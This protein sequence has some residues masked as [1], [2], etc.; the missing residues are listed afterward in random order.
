MDKPRVVVSAILRDLKDGLTRDAIG[1]KYGLDKTG[2]KELFQNKH[3]KN[4]KTHKPKESRF[5]LI[6]D[7]DEPDALQTNGPI[8]ADVA[9][10]QEA[11]LG[12]SEATAE[13][14]EEQAQTV[15]ESNDPF[16]EV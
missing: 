16:A 8:V 2:V 12:Q 13:I 11:A 4:K 5:I 15:R 6:D 9:D 3:L 7:I 1:E 10:E 14:V